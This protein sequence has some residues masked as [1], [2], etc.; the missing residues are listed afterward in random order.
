[1]RRLTSLLLAA[2]ALGLVGRG[3]VPC[4]ALPAQ[5]RCYVA[6]HPG[7][8]QDTLAGLSIDARTY[9]P[10]GTFLVTT[11]AVDA[12]LGLVEWLQGGVSPR[13]RQVPRAEL[14]PPGETVEAVRRRNVVQMDESQ[15]A[16]SAAALRSLGY[17]VD[18]APRGAEVVELL[19]GA[20]AAG[21]LEVGDVVVALDGRPVRS[22]QALADAVDR[23]AVGASV[24]LTVRR[25][26]TVREV[27]V[28]VADDPAEPGAR[29]LGVSV[30]DDVALPVPIEIDAGP[31]GGPSAGLLFAVAIV[32]ALTPD[33][34]TGGRVIA[35]TGTIDAA[36]RVGAI[37]GIR[38]KVLGAVERAPGAPASVFLVPRGNL[39]EAQ[40]APV[41]RGILL[42]PVST[43]DEAVAALRSLRGG[44]R[45]DGAVA[46]G[47]AR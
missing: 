35:G 30:R 15:L 44:R 14:Y 20:P 21:A 41:A 22:A 31:V 46:L 4:E 12:E 25:E 13:V 11:V 34:L 36:G 6:L 17:D 2:A 32:D 18:T 27:E 47:A 1:M 23:R 19:P 10:S 9:R 29:S 42:V 39:P 45:P 33:D 7:P 24:A 40:R 26:G 8:T 28:V 3:A 43:L 16:A 37:G 38:Q 5:P